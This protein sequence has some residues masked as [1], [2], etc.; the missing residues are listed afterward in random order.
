MISS[1]KQTFDCLA[2]SNGVQ[3][4]FVCQCVSGR[5]F[6]EEYVSHKGMARIFWQSVE[7]FVV[8]VPT[9]Q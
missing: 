3:P 5:W 1:L 9:G 4:C 8:W 7:W 2:C 6:A